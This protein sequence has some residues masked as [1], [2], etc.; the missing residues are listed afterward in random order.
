MLSK[1]ASTNC[2][3][4]RSHHHKCLCNPAPM[5]CPILSCPLPL[6]RT[7]SCSRVGALLIRNLLHVFCSSHHFS[8]LCFLMWCCS[9]DSRQVLSSEWFT[10]LVC[11]CTPKSLASSR[12]SSV[13]CRTN[14]AGSM[15]ASLNTSQ[16]FFRHFAGL[17]WSG[18]FIH[19]LFFKINIL[20]CLLV[21]FLLGYI[22]HIS[23][24][25]NNIKLI[26]VVKLLTSLQHLELLREKVL[27]KGKDLCMW[28]NLFLNFKVNLHCVFLRS[29][30]FSNQFRV[31]LLI[32]L[33]L[34]KLLSVSCCLI[35]L[36]V[37]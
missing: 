22:S 1:K 23:Y 18:S 13:G 8:V 30:L 9:V 20:K 21:S 14:T 34:F 19:F 37:L 10:P 15:D 33:F 36:S 2:I 16:L 12:L 4:L 5:H 17:N 25:W 29:N 24:E 3:T 35:V 27:C 11:C 28:Q 31:F 6:L 26:N 7:S 32:F